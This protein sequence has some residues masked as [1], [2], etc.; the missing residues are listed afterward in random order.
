M[1][2]CLLEDLAASMAKHQIPLTLD[3]WSNVHWWSTAVSQR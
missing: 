3:T 1:G 2:A